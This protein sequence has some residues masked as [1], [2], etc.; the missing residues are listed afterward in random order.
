MDQEKFI[1]LIRQ[2]ES[3]Y[4]RV[5]KSILKKDA[6]VEDAVQEGIL[7]AWQKRNKLKDISLFRTWSTRIVIN[8]CYDH[9][10]KTR[11]LLPFGDELPEVSD[12]EA[13][14]YTELYIA[15]QDLPPKFRIVIV[16]YYVEGYSTAEIGSILK[17]PQGTVK[18]RLSKGRELLKKELKEEL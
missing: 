15:I 8:S 3:T 10:R 13:E 9:I 4:Y 7:K 1:S 6:D 5:A 18:S 17:I 11:P 2:S 12:P 16:L 14:P